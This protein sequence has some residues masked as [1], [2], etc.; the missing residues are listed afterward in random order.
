MKTRLRI[1]GCFILL[2]CLTPSSRV[3]A[4]ILKAGVA[5]VEITPPAGTLMWG[6]FDRQSG[7]QGMLDPLLARILVL[8]AGQKR[9]ALVSLDL[10]RPFGPESMSWLKERITKNGSTYLIVS[11]THTHSGPVLLDRYPNGA[12]DWEK[13]ALE[14]I[15]AAIDKASGSVIEV[16]LGTG[17]GVAYIGYNRRRVNENGTVTML[18]ENETRVPTSPLDPTV[19]ILRIDTVRGDPLAILVNYACHPV[20]LGASNLQFSADFTGVVAKQVEQAFPEHPT[21]FYLQGACGDINPYYA[22]VALEQNPVKWRDW[23]GG[24]LAR[25]VIRVSKSIRPEAAPSA[26][27]EFAEDTLNFR[28]RYE[29]TAFRQSLLKL[30]GPKAFE[31]FSPS[32]QKEYSL[33]VVT[34]LI[35]KRIGLMGMPGEPFVE[36]Q[37]SWRERCPVGDAL[38]LGYCNGYYGY[39]PTLKAASEGGYGAADAVTWVEPGSGERMLNQSLSRIYGFLGKLRDRPEN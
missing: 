31:T 14:K 4:A 19:S 33:P 17:Y 30:L 28:L 1:L 9:L 29:M 20:I 32:I 13:S 23:T 7:A 38:F 37:H 25:E 12:P 8:E 11:A 15:A 34:L 35:N 18:W 21:V 22:D 10:G 26:T 6:F 5:S 36:F 39:F 16:R 2:L 24:Q 3:I 27:L